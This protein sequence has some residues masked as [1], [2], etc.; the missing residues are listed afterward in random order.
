M[1]FRENYMFPCNLDIYNK[2]RTF[3]L[4]NHFR[5]HEHR[6]SRRAFFT[7]ILV[8]YGTPPMTVGGID[9][10]FNFR[11]IGTNAESTTFY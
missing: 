7:Y 9:L 1:I 6:L 8:A 5:K 11:P 4:G 10:T 3:P 2:I